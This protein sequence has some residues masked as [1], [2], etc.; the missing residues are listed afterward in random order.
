M[1]SS[2]QCSVLLIAALTTGIGHAIEYDV[3]NQQGQVVGKLIRDRNSFSFRDRRNGDHAFTYHRQPEHDVNKR[4]VGFESDEMTEN[5]VVRLPYGN[6]GPLM[7][8]RESGWHQS[9]ERITPSRSGPS[10]RQ[11][12]NSDYQPRNPTYPGGYNNPDFQGSGERGGN[13]IFV[14]PNGP[15]GNFGN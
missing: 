5:N 4:W 11:P 2:I 9:G 6:N 8:L 10:Q 3:L 13:P 1:W 12:I 15:Y 7:V 14:F